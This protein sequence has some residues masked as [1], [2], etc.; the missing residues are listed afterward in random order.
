MLKSKLSYKKKQPTIYLI[1][2]YLLPQAGGLTKALYDKAK[3]LSN[4]FHVTIITL[5]FQLHL[6]DIHLDLIKND[7]L[8]ENITIKNFFVDIGKQNYNLFHLPL[9][10][11]YKKVLGN[12]GNLYTNKSKGNIRIFNTDG[13]Y[14]FYIAKNNNKSIKFIDF[15][16][17]MDYEKLEKRYTF[18][19]NKLT[20][21][22]TYD[23]NRHKKQQIIYNKRR[24][25]ILSLW[26]KNNEVSH[27]FDMRNKKTKISS[28]EKLYQSWLQSF[29]NQN[30]IILIDYD[31]SKNEK[32]FSSINCKK[33]AFIHSHQDYCNDTKFLKSFSGFDKFVF[34]TTLQKN[35]FKNINPELHDKSTLIP[36]PIQK[37]EKLPNKEKKIVTISRLVPGKPIIPAIHAFNRIKNIFPLYNYEIYGIGPDKEKI[38]Q[39]I[40][41]LELQDRVFLKGYTNA[42]LEIF[43]NSELSIGLTNYEGF[44]LSILESLSMSC[45]VITSNVNYGPNEM[46]KN[47]FNGY[48]IT[49]NNI[50]DIENAM[51]QILSNPIKYQM[52]CTANLEAYLLEK[53]EKNLLNLL[54]QI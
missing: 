25:P 27:V 44:G 47:D 42:P 4:H 50:D 17:S 41:E 3:F 46:V 35:D 39:L 15:M 33:I 13:T 51:V 20:S 32:L 40:N 1:A 14:Q 19:Q 38:E 52:N 48:L 30:D 53:W 43:K 45:P 54:N 28:L 5:N 2:H 16:D 31:F 26:F 36:H 24:R 10:H 8:N 22:E 49:G 9:R 37:I 7:K 18:F 12:L 23:S 6:E 21:L 29:I 11:E 34:L